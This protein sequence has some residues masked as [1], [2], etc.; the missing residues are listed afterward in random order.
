MIMSVIKSIAAQPNLVD[1]VDV[2]ITRAAQILTCERVTLFHVHAESKTISVEASGGGDDTSN[3]HDIHDVTIPLD[4]SSL[5]GSAAV[6]RGIA[7]RCVALRGIALRC[8]A[9]RC[10]ALRCVALRCVAVRLPCFTLLRFAVLSD[11]TDGQVHHVQR[12]LRGTTLRQ[13]RGRANW[14]SMPCR[15]S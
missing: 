15:A 4:E 10:V 1:A 12:C 11:D 9:L 6:V 3:R 5:A 8:V 14:V 13:V 2:L 7:L